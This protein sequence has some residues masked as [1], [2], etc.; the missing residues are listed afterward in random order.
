VQNVLVNGIVVIDKGEHTGAK[1]GKALRGPGVQ[2]R[3]GTKS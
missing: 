1:P 2:E 3:K